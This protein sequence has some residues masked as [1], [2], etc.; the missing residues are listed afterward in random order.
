MRGRGRG[1][2]KRAGGRDRARD[3]RERASLKY[4]QMAGHPDPVDVTAARRLGRP[5]GKNEER[6]NSEV[7]SKRV[8]NYRVQDDHK[9]SNYTGNQSQS[10]LNEMTDGFTEPLEGPSQNE[11]PSTAGNQT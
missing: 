3:G 10:S 2:T 4:F 7:R 6:W 8:A 11:E 1:Q 9:S 5:R